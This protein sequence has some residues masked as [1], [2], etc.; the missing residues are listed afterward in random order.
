MGAREIGYLFGRYR[1]IMNRHE[2]GMFT[3]KGVAW[4]GA[5]VRTEA[6][7]YGTVFFL[8]QMLE[9][10]GRAIEGLNAVVSGS[11]N[12]ALY[13]IEKIQ[14]LGERP[15]RRPIPPVTSSMRRASTS[16]CSS[17]SRRSSDCA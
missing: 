2:S 16:I 14:Q 11:G 4:G 1:K 5:E 17:R 7:G 13:A 6:T 9:R 15:S 10:S 12:V 3:G 8:E